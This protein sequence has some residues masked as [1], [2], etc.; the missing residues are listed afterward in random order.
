MVNIEYLSNDAMKNLP[1]AEYVYI[2]QD[3]DVSGRVK[4]GRTKD[5]Q[6]RFLDFGVKLP[7]EIGIIRVI[8][9]LDA[10]RFERELHDKYAPKRK[11][12]E[13]FELGDKEKL[14]LLCMA[15]DIQFSTPADNQATRLLH[16]VFGYKH[17]KRASIIESRQTKYFVKIVQL[18]NGNIELMWMGNNT[19]KIAE[20][21]NFRQIE[22]TKQ[23][24]P[25]DIK[26]TKMFNQMMQEAIRIAELWE[27][28][29]I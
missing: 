20:V 22:S 17:F 27:A 25:R 1:N 2:I 8:P 12:G 3:L 26:A 21:M 16:E 11:R 14:E 6:Q 4:I 5:P 29:L 10:V 23:D 24:F 7:F 18:E 13:W 19:H 9:T 28:N 15:G